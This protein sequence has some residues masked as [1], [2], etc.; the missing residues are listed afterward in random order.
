MNFYIVSWKTK[1]KDFI[2]NAIPL[3]LVNT[4]DFLSMYLLL[5]IRQPMTVIRIYQTVVSTQGP[6]L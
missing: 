3:N 6:H 2:L 1:L 5:I 4:Q